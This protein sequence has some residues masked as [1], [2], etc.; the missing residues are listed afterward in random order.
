MTELLFRK[1]A[2]AREAVGTVKS[3]TTEG[4]IVLDGTL[5]YPTSGGSRATA[6]PC[7]GKAAR[8]RSRRPLRA[9]VMMWS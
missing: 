2:Y 3:I 7:A 1:D 4:G 5:F 8:S 9:T 6:A